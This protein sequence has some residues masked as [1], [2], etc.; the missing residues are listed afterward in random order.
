MRFDLVI[1]A[2]L[3]APVI[4]TFPSCGTAGINCD[5]SSFTLSCCIETNGAV[6]LQRCDNT[7]NPNSPSGILTIAPCTAGCSNGV[8]QETTCCNNKDGSSLC[9]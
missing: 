5:E 9:F 3:V 7:A 4:A 6:G 8:G 2:V 1:A